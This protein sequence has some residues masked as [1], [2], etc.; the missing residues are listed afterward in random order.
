M[1]ET[2]YLVQNYIQK[3][4]ER[5]MQLEPIS[6][7]KEMSQYYNTTNQSQAEAAVSASHY[8]VGSIDVYGAFSIASNPSIHKTS[9]AA[10]AEAKRLAGNVPGKTFVVMQLISGYRAG[11]ILEF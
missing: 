5:Y 8:I 9:Q 4:T 6:E 2:N 1:F 3:H 7:L 11:G 10:N